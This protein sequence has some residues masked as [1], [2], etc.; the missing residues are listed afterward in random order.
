MSIFQNAKNKFSE[1][2]EKINFT[3][4]CFK[5]QKNTPKVVTIKFFMKNQRDFSV[6]K[7]G[8]EKIPKILQILLICLLL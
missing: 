4:G 6:S 5:F 8:N 7:N 1:K 3:Q 2:N